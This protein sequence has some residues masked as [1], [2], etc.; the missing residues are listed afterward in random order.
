MS[1]QSQR[2]PLIDALK[3]VAALLVLMNHFSS[4][5]PLAE[6]ARD[7]FPSVFNWLFE[8]GR[9]AVQVFLVIGGFLAAR[10]LS[11]NGQALDASP[12]PLIWKRYLRLAVPGAR[13]VRVASD[14]GWLPAPQ[15]VGDYLL[16][17]GERSEFVVTFPHHAGTPL[18]LVSLPYARQKMMSPEQTAPVPLLDIG[19]SSGR[20]PAAPFTL[21]A[22]LRPVVP[23]GTPVRRR[24]IV[25]DERPHDMAAHA[26]HAM[27]DPQRMAEGL[28]LIDGK[29]YDMERVD[30]EARVGEVEAWEVVNRSHMD[31]PF[32]LHGGRFQLVAIDGRPVTPTWRDTVNLPPRS[33]LTLLT[34]F[35]HPGDLLYHCHILE[36]EDAGMMGQFTVT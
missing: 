35:D 31:H 34:R 13:L 8:Y 12:L 5:G 26:G 6:A 21:P 25:L 29:T 9:M 16:V 11:A 33:R 32:H 17:P 2:M 30:L 23:L 22:T 28:F 14:G 36:H 27:A 10:G 7:Y 20:E 15:P 1:R 3:A 18:T 24:E 4:Y 19:I